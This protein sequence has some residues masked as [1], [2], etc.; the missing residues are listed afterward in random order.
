M[1]KMTWNRLMLILLL[2]IVCMA[3]AQGTYLF[4]QGQGQKTSFIEAGPVDRVLVIDL[5]VAGDFEAASAFNPDD[6]ILAV[7]N[8]S[9]ISPHENDITA[10]GDVFNF[11]NTYSTNGTISLSDP[12]FDR[13]ELLF[14][15]QNNNL[16]IRYSSLAAAGIRAIFINRTHHLSIFGMSFGRRTY[17]VGT[18]LMADNTT[19]LIR[20]VVLVRDVNPT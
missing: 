18:V 16:Q 7:Q 17:A 3:L 19:R 20:E 9:A 13:L 11:L 1:L 2:L 14:L 15:D 6:V 8:G 4:Y 5:N 12:V 10:G